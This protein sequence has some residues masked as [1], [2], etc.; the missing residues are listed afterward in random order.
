MS[1]GGLGYLKT[2][3]GTLPTVG[4]DLRVGLCGAGW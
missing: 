2:T 1:Q 4:K 3:L